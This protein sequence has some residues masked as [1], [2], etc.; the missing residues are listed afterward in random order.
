MTGFIIYQIHQARTILAPDSDAFL[1]HR[2]VQHPGYDA[3]SH[4][5]QRV[6]GHSPKILCPLQRAM[7]IRIFLLWH[8]DNNPLQ[9]RSKPIGINLTEYLYRGYG[10]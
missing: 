8:T 1:Q 10:Q 3:V 9:D 7:L 5:I 6:G 4:G 2:C